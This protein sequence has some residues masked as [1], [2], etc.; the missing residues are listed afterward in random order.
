LSL[1]ALILVGIVLYGTI[2]FFMCGDVGAAA[3]SPGALGSVVGYVGGAV[4]GLLILAIPVCTTIVLYL[5][6]KRRY[7]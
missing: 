1:R 3:C 7:T 2:G 5:W 4:A 6:Q